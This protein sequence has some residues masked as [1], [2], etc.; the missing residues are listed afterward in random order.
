MAPAR[1]AMLDGMAR[2][3]DLPIEELTRRYRA[4]APLRQLAADY[5]TSTATV[6]DR[7]DRAGVDVRRRGAPR[8]EVD[9]AELAYET[10]LAGSVRAAARTLGLSHTTAGRRLD[11]LRQQHPQPV[12]TPSTPG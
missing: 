9:L 1:F 3:V 11:E 4:G 2:R 6:R 7:L 8:R 10:H 5:R 12:G